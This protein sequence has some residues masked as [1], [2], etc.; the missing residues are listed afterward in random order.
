VAFGREVDVTFGVQRGGSDEEYMLGADEF[1]NAFGDAVIDF[2][3]EI[4]LI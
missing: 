4:P 3:H 2:A 1:V